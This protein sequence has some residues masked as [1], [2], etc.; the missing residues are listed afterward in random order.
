M[1]TDDLRHALRLNEACS[2]E[3]SAV[4]FD[5]RPRQ[6]TPENGSR[7][8]Y[9]GAKRRAGR[10]GHVAV[11]PLGHVLANVVTP[12]NK[13]DRA[14]VGGLAQQVHVALLFNRPHEK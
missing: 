4:V 2:A 6:R 1:A 14:Q 7:A 12:A 11:D 13:Q 3:P 10:Q 9:D 8:G 5:P